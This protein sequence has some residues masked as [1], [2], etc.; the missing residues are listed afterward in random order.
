MSIEKKINYQGEEIINFLG[1]LIGESYNYKN[2]NLLFSGGADSS[3]LLYLMRKYQPKQKIK[4]I[5]FNS[6]NLKYD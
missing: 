2:V 4:S 6:G 3:L 5:F 1:K